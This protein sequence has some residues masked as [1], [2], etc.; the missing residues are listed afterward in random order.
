MPER[1]IAPDRLV[2][3]AGSGLDADRLDGQ[4]AEKFAAAAGLSALEARV[5][6]AEIDVDGV[7]DDLDDHGVSTNPHPGVCCRWRGCG[8]MAPDSPVEGDMYFNT[9]SSIPYLYADGQW[10]AI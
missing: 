9:S 10:R 3:G 7:K 4:S 2:H 6:Q 5:T 8:P 1:K